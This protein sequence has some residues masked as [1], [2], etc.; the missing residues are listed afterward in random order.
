MAGKN[1]TS[2]AAAQPKSAGRRLWRVMRAVLYMLRRGVLP[3]GRKVAMDL[4]LLLRR[5]KIGGKPSEVEHASSTQR[6]GRNRR[7]RED[8]AA[9]DYSAA[10]IAKV[11]E[12]LND[13]GNLF[14]DD[15]TLRVTESPCA[16]EQQVDRKANEFIR[17]FYEQ[18]RA[19]KS[20]PATPDCYVYA[21]GSYVQRVPRPVAAGIA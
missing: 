16:G 10:D 15:D 6:R 13:G 20:V 18:L 8:E 11:L 17:R 1:V 4:C 19:Q 7:Q 2:K 3:S 12:M 21:G 5:G 9:S 14:G